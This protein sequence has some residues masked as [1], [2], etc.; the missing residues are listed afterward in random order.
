MG[1]VKLLKMLLTLVLTLIYIPFMVVGYCVTR[2]LCPGE[3]KA[4][5]LPVYRRTCANCLSLPGRQ[6]QKFAIGKR[7]RELT[8]QA[9]Q[10]INEKI[11]TKASNRRKARLSAHDRSR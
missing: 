2:L 10:N 8:D 1:P 6:A 11:E 7:A 4:A 5:K 9:L 3:H